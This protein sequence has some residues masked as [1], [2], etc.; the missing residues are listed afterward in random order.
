MRVKR[1]RSGLVSK[2]LRMACLGV[3]LGGMAPLDA[4]CYNGSPFNQ[5][6]ESSANSWYADCRCDCHGDPGCA[7]YS[8]LGPPQYWC[9]VHHCTTQACNSLNPSAWTEC[10]DGSQVWNAGCCAGS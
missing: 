9:V 7:N 10:L 2:T 4:D 1:K 3:A 8:G 5:G 6:T